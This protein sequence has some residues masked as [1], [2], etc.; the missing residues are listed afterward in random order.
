LETILPEVSTRQRWQN[1]MVVYPL[2]RR[3]VIAAQVMTE[4]EREE[5]RSRLGLDT[6]QVETIP[7][8]RAWDR[9]D[10]IG[11]R[12][13][14]REIVVASGRAACDW[15]TF[16]AATA[17]QGWEVVAVCG[18]GDEQA[19][20]ALASGRG[21]CTVMCEITAAE[22]H[23]LLKRAR[24]YVIPL[25]EVGHSSGQ[26]RVMN[27]TTAGA[28]V[29]TSDVKALAGY[30]TNGETAMLVPAGDPGALRQAIRRLHAD[31]RLAA[32]LVDRAQ[33]HALEWTESEYNSAL[34]AFVADAS[35]R[36]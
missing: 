9:N 13:Q 22:H 34:R 30:V 6:A 3:T 18:R 1:K 29:V 4:W 26:V 16:F 12:D 15:P 11:Y 33:Q 19:V 25:R 36:I 8:G 2:L 14:R 21:D 27:A 17:G 32:G 5:L 23:E 24:V 31:T 7:V 20:R 28:P 10:L 35:A